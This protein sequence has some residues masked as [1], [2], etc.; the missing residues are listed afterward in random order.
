MPTHVLHALD[1]AIV[2]VY[3]LAT[4]LLGV[5]FTRRQRDLNTY[6]V[7]ER[8]VA[9]PLI[10]VSIVATET[11][12]VTFLSVPGLAFDPRGGNLTFLQLAF[13]YILGRTFI[14]WILLPQYLRGQLFSAY[15]LLRLRFNPAVQRLAS[16]TFLLTRAV[17]DGLRLYLAAL[18]LQQFTGWDTAAS[19][20]VIGAATMLYTYL[21]GMQ[22][23]IWTDLIQFAIYITGALIA[24]G[25]IVRHVEGGWAGFWA[26][27]AGEGKFRWLDFTTDPTLP[28]TFWA[29]LVGGAFLTMASHGAD[30][31][32]VQRYLCSRSLAGARLAL[33]GSG[34]VV[35]AQFLLFLLIGA[36]LFV[37]VQ[38]GS[39]PLEPGTP[40]DAVFGRFIVDDLPTGLVGLLVAAVLASSMASL[41]SSLSSGA[42]AFVGDFYRPLRPGRTE[43]HYLGVSRCMT[44][45]WG[46][47]RI[48]VALAGVAVLGD[49]SVIG[50]VLSVA[51]LTT[52]V[53]LG[54]FLLG[55]MRRPVSSGAALVGL[56]AGA[57]IVATVWLE[58]PVAWPWYAPVG[59]LATVGV[60]LLVNKL[61]SGHGSPGNRGPEPGLDEPGRADAAGTRPPD[62]RGGHPRR[63]RRGDAGGGNCPGD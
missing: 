36:G 32:M 59:T 38:Q 45:V 4:T 48:A 30:Q 22:A 15:Q 55:S 54:L 17:A 40:N 19:V 2:V 18:L 41:A 37:L 6:F 8:N 31:M 9:W 46:V 34:F 16:G 29:G 51:G 1:V 25:C 43:A 53:I 12:T 3:L 57:V 33:V 62:E 47:T 10:L 52:G 56:A 23:V 20:V 39:L 7:G 13:G 58:A 44:S 14:A 26:A 42:S 28:Y 27:G 50:P 35:L 24:A 21:G 49:T 61:R 11:S 63:V 60:A 5:W